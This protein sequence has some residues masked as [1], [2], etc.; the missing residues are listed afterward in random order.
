MK[1]WMKGF[2]AIVSTVTGII[3]IAENCNCFGRYDPD[4]GELLRAIAGILL[5]GGGATY[6]WTRSRFYK[7]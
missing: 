6:F 3:L 5:L 1:P 4:I 7:D 2:V